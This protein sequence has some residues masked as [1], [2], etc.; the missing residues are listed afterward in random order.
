MC[1]MCGLL[2]MLL[3]INFKCNEFPPPPLIPS[4]LLTGKVFYALK[5]IPRSFRD[6][7]EDI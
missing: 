2:D 5:N 7:E 4:L 3:Y 6:R 1:V